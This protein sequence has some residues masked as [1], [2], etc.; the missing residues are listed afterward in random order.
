[1]VKTSNFYNIEAAFTVS[2]DFSRSAQTISAALSY[3]HILQTVQREQQASNIDE[4]KTYLVEKFNVRVTI[5]I[6]AKDQHSL[7]KIGA[8]M[9]GNDVI[10][11][12]NI[13]EE[14]LS[15]S[16]K[17][18]YYEK[19]IQ[20]F[21]DS[22]PRLTRHFAAMGLTY[23]PCGVVIHEDG[24]VTYI[25]GGGDSPERVEE[26]RRINELKQQKKWDR[27]DSLNELMLKME[28]WKNQAGEPILVTVKK[29]M[30]DGSIE[31]ITKEDGKIIERLTKKPHLIAVHDPLTDKV[32]MEPFVSIF[33]TDFM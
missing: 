20:D 32:K 16:S 14:M 21:F 7:D 29:I 5:E 27:I 30:P 6:V 28:E 10:I 9:S 23:E 19:K 3:T 22:T 26:V 1:M 18:E 31:T 25:C 13:F 17:A 4:Y 11:A 33:D 12:P 2:T 15:D 8:R 24:S